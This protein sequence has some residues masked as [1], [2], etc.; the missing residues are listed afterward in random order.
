MELETPLPPDMV[1]VREG[2]DFIEVELGADYQDND[3]QLEAYCDNSILHI[4]FLVYSWSPNQDEMYRD[5]Y[6]KKG[7]Q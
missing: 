4:L 1:E 7:F 5:L 2:R 3:S 6:K